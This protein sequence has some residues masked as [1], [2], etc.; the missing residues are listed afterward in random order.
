MCISL[1]SSGSTTHARGVY[2]Y[3]I[4]RARRRLYQRYDRPRTE[5]HSRPFFSLSFA[6][7]LLDESLQTR[8]SGSAP[9]MPLS[10]LDL[11]YELRE[12]ILNL[13]LFTTGSIKLQRPEEGLPAYT[14]PILQVC[15]LLRD[16]AARVFYHVN[17]FTWTIDP[18]EVSLWSSLQQ[19]YADGCPANC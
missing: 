2:R 13:V 3:H 12:Q 8:S 4:G 15:R 11:P 14:P 19:F 7:G 16:E 18:E 5:H 1:V 17:T 10:L 6:D 9:D